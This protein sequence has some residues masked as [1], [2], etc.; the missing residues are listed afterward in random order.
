MCNVEKSL[1]AF[2]LSPLA[3][4]AI[5]REGFTPRSHSMNNNQ[6]HDEVLFQRGVKDDRELRAPRTVCEVSSH[7]IRIC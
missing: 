1:I 3:G 6:K 5:D 7:N 2:S 4:M